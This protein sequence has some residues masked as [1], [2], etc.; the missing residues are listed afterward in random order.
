MTM[1]MSQYMC[2]RDH[3]KM[4]ELWTE[5]MNK[6]NLESTPCPKCGCYCS[7]DFDCNCGSVYD[8]YCTNCGRWRS[9]PVNQYVTIY[10]YDVRC[11]LGP[12]MHIHSDEE[13]NNRLKNWINSKLKER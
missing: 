1:N 2:T 13:R 3:N 5:N 8:K 6:I 7:K 4:H 11:E 12:V 10:G 9:L